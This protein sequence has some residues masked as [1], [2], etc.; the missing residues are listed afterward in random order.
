MTSVRFEDENGTKYG[1]AHI[2]NKPFVVNSPDLSEIVFG[3]VSGEKIMTGLGERESIGTTAAGEDITRMNELSNVP[4]ALASD[5]LVPTPADAGEQMSL[6]S[7]SAEDNSASAGAGTINVEYLDASGDEQTTSVSMDG[8]AAVPLT[9][10]DVRFVNDMYVTTLGAN[11]VSGVAA[12]HIRIYQTADATLVYNMIAA[13]GNKS[14]VPHRM[15]PRA[16]SLYLKEWI[17]AEGN[18]KRL[19]MRLR[20]DCDNAAP[21]VRQAGVFL[22]KSV[23]YVNQSVSG[24]M[25]LGYRIPALSMVKASAW[26]SAINGEASVHWWGILRDD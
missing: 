17:C 22:F 11:N 13:G 10:S 23:V 15:I 14:L 9:P 16:K 21:P 26:A 5:V 6:I 2:G 20:S 3:N 18:N 24:A 8:T 25:P 12:G 7:E 4:A 1:I 19:T